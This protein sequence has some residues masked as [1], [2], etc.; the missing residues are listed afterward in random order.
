MSLQNHRGAVTLSEPEISE[1]VVGDRQ[2]FENN[3]SLPKI[4]DL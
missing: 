4:G 2:P 1:L 3:S